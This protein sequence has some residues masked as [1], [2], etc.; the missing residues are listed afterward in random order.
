VRRRLGANFGNRPRVPD[1]ATTATKD[2]HP[3]T[4]PLRDAAAPYRQNRR[5]TAGN[6]TRPSP[7]P[8]TTRSRPRRRGTCACSREEAS[9]P[10]RPIGVPVAHVGCRV[11][12]ASPASGAEIDRALPTADCAPDLGDLPTAW[13]LPNARTMVLQSLAI[14]LP[15]GLE[16]TV[17]SR[18]SCGSNGRRLVERRTVA[19]ERRNSVRSCSQLRIEDFTLG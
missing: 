4:S 16:A 14:H 6:S 10:A 5:S 12:A 9:L 1:L 17:S 8:W 2:S 19:L 13:K 3:E 15:S 11:P 7:L 18:A